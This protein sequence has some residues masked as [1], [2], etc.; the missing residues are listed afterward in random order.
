[1]EP[2]LG[3]HNTYTQ[4]AAEAGIPAF[5]TF[6]ALLVWCWRAV[7]RLIRATRGD[8]RPLAQDIYST[9]VTLR[10]A[11]G[12]FCCF[13]LFDHMA[14]DM[15]PHFFVALC[16]VASRTAGIELARLNPAPAVAPAPSPGRFRAGAPMPAAAH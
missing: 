7:S 4:I 12:T 15:V 11:L 13:I 9:A 10:V 6:I 3:T 5:V 2:W 14:Y 1:M 8:P 16:V